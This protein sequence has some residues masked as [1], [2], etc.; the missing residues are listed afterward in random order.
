MSKDFLELK[1]TTDASV[2]SSTENML[3]SDER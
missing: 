3:K 2:N 1:F